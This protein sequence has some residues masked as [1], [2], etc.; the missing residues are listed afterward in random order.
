[1]QSLGGILS[2]NEL[3]DELCFYILIQNTTTIA[4]MIP[5][6]IMYMSNHDITNHVTSDKVMTLLIISAEPPYIDAIS[7]TRGEYRNSSRS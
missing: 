4:G 2:D 1:M 6:C 3:D 5:S 7:S